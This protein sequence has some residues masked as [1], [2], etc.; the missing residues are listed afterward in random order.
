[1]KLEGK[2]EKIFW[3]ILIIVAVAIWFQ[4]GYNTGYSKGY[5]EGY[6]YSYLNRDVQK[7]PVPHEFHEDMSYFCYRCFNYEGFRVSHDCYANCIGVML[8]VNQEQVDQCI[9]YMREDK[10]RKCHV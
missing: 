3:S 8:N 4:N 9:Q 2:K 10:V 7:Y 5:N 1:M 6:D